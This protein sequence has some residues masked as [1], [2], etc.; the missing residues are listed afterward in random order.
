MYQLTSKQKLALLAI[1]VLMLGSIGLLAVQSIRFHVT[2]TDPKQNKK[3]NTY[4]VAIL[5]FNRPI[6]ADNAQ[7]SA[8]PSFNFTK[9][10]DDKKLVIRPSDPLSNNTAYVVKVSGVCEKAKPASCLSYTLKFSTDNNI[11]LSNQSSEQQK[12]VVANV[13]SQYQDNPITAI[14]PV[15]ETDFLIE[16]RPTGDGYS[17]VVITPN[18]VADTLTPDEYNAAY[19]RYLQEGKD[20]LTN[21]GYA[22]QGSKYKVVG[23]QEFTQI[24]SGG[25]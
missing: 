2:S 21:K 6:N 8:Q 17:Y 3:I 9:S 11:P 19:A 15:N 13:D 4:N 20:Y 16:D 14:L 23:S 7:I 22:L 5:Y 10:V 12:Q 25:D 24:T 1:V 18:I